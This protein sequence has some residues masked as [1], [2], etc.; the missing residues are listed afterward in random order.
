MAHTQ[1]TTKT[2]VITGTVQLLLWRDQKKAKKEA[3]NAPPE[4]VEQK[5][6][7]SDNS[8]VPAKT[9]VDIV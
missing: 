2:V 9:A 5:G 4:V 6:D 7:E 8:R 1:L 3:L